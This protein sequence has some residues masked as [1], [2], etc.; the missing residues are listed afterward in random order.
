MSRDPIAVWA[1]MEM[2]TWPESYWFAHVPPAMLD[3]VV[4]MLGYPSKAYSAVNQDQ[5][6][7]SLVVDEERWQRFF[8]DAGEVEKYGPVKV[9]STDSDLPFDVTGFIQAALKPINGAGFKAAPQC[10][11]MHDHFVVPAGDIHQVEAIF[12]DFRAQSRLNTAG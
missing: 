2:K 6:G 1:A 12:S 8:A 4:A 11:I 3:R 10:G 9:M 5:N 7:F